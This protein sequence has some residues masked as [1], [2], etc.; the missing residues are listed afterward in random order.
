MRG[1]WEG[2]WCLMRRAR[3]LLL[4]AL[5]V[6]WLAG[7][8]WGAQARSAIL[9]IGDG[10]GIAHVQ[11]AAG[12]AQFLGKRPAI[13]DLMR[14][15]QGGLAS[16]FS[17]NSPITDSAAAGTALAT[18]VKTNNG[19]LSVMPDGTRAETI[20]ERCRQAGKS[21]GLVT[22]TRITHAT[23]AAFAAHVR[24]RG[25]EEE[26]AVQ[27]LSPGVDVLLGGGRRE[28]L[29]TSAG[30]DRE[31]GRNLLQE[32]ERAG[33]TLALKPQDLAAIRRLPLLGLFAENE[34]GYTI[35]Q[36]KEEPTLAQMT[37]KA[38]E[39]LGAE[40]D[41]FFLMV[42]G[43]EIDYGAH[44]NDLATMIH[45]VLAFDEAVRVAM[46]FVAQ[47]PDTLLVVTADHETGGLTLPRPVKWAA[48]REQ[49]VS[50]E[51]VGQEWEQMGKTLHQRLR[52][53]EQRLGVSLTAAEK[54]RL[55]RA[56]D[57][58]EE[59]GGLLARM[60]SERAGVAWSTYDHTA[61]WVPVVATGPGSE[62]IRALQDNTD[63]NRVLQSALGVGQVSWLEEPRGWALGIGIALGVPRHQSALQ[64]MPIDLRR[65]VQHLMQ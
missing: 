25:E 28:F 6:L 54:A 27:L 2:D 47:H 65:S 57:N 55:L 56:S 61:A 5:L 20:L 35:D 36:P 12:Y 7:A 41:G 22:K 59:M 11:A 17:A 43:G 44:A 64:F 32:A 46:E 9:M 23:P 31:D 15:G 58:L 50:I 60:I 14:L 37:A 42:E 51:K 40:E 13:T 62:S 38:L 26:I 21:V 1:R 10:M 49:P 53:A 30:G 52:A 39:L 48:V 3:A 24:S 8:A 45:E 33:Y 19:M 29:P 16:T 4:W 18:G 63:V 34:L